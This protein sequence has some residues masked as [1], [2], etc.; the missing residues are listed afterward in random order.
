MDRTGIEAIF[1]VTRLVRDG[2]NIKTAQRL[3]RHSDPKL[4]LSAYTHLTI[5]DD[6]AALEA[7]PEIEPAKDTRAN[8]T[9]GP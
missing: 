2:V 9:D 6:A 4:T 8:G 7:L 5:T 1:Y 3:A